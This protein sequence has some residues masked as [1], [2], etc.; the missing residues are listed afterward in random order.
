MFYKKT[1]QNKNINTKSKTYDLET[2]K[3]YDYKYFCTLD[4]LSS[5]GTESPATW[6][7]RNPGP[8]GQ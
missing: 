8:W 6:S 2:Q 7:Q 1:K 3:C 5:T 4:D